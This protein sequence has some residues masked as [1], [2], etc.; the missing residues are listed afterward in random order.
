MPRRVPADCILSVAFRHGR[1]PAK[2][3]G[4]RRVLDLLYYV[5]KRDKTTE[6]PP[7]ELSSQR[8][9]LQIA[10]TRRGK[11][12]PRSAG[13]GSLGEQ[14]IRLPCKNRARHIS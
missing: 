4:A 8:G 11:K 12:R 14:M 2:I 10:P 1:N 9:P 6:C 7:L 13:G 3:A 5:L